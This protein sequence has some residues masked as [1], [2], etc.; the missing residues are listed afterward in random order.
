MQSPGLSRRRLLGGATALSGAGLLS[1]AGITPFSVAAQ[2]RSS[3]TFAYNF[4]P[5]SLDPTICSGLNCAWATNHLYEGLTRFDREGNVE[6]CLAESW[7]NP[8]PLTWDFHLRQ[9][10]KFHNGA[11]LSAEDVK[12]SIDRVLDPEMPGSNRPYFSAINNVEAVDQS[13]VRFHLNTPYVPLLGSLATQGGA[14]I[15]KQWAEE[16]VAAGAVEFTSVEMG[17]GP[18]MLLE[19]VPGDRLDYQKFADYWDTGTPQIDDVTWKIMQELETRVAS[20]RAKTASYAQIDSLGAQQLEG[21]GHVTLY[22][23]PGFAMPVSIH[24]VRRAPFD[25]IRV[26]QAIALGVDRQEMIEKVFGGEGSLTGPVQTGFGDWFIP[27]EELPYKV[28]RDAAKALLAEAG[29][30]DGFD[31][32]ILGLDVWPYNDVGI[33]YQAQLQAIGINASIEQT[34][35]GAWLDKIHDF[36]FETHVNGYAF[37]ADPEMIL[38]RSFQCDSDGN[39]PGYCDPAYDEQLLQLQSESDHVK[40]VEVSRSMQTMLLDA[41]PFI[42]W[43][44]QYDYYATTDQITGFE[45]AIHS[46]PRE[47]FKRVSV[48]SEG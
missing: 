17:T 34:E 31:T 14:I 38:G 30:P 25:D 4:D 37:N 29:Y 9:G 40:R 36:D 42:W 13:T 20:L 3:A 39:F 44:T 26:R 2:D 33:V 16:Q 11:E 43:C 19:Y 35:F 22:S 7:E 10:V 5:A 23:N 21:T 28:D 45:P 27:V 12:Y 8:D 41:T 47:V 6:P 46:F 48:I 15:N 18:Y 24:N 1:H 32:T